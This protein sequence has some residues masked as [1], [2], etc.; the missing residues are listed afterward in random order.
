MYKHSYTLVVAGV[1]HPCTPNSN[2]RHADLFVSPLSVL[3]VRTA[4][5]AVFY[6]VTRR[7]CQLRQRRLCPYDDKMHLV[8]TER[9][10]ILARRKQQ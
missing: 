4:C 9:N 5:T 3:Y 1:H 2:H 8:V 6:S 7:T 10:E